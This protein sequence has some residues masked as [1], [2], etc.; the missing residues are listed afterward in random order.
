MKRTLSILFTLC[1]ISLACAEG[2]P[3]KSCKALEINKLTQKLEVRHSQI[4]YRS[5][6]LFYTFKE[7]KT[8]LKIEIDNQDKKF[9]ITATVYI[10]EER[11]TE[12]GLKKWLNNQHSDGLFPEVPR[13]ITTCNIPPKICKVTSHK[14][15]GHS[16]ERFGE[17]DNYK[18]TFEVKDYTDKINIKLKGF[19]GE[20]KVHIKTK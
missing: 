7:Q 20:S 6:L 4:D 17:Y 11:V 2:S 15:T 5:T 1:F 12:D 18:V 8:V 19:T 10:F 9:P 3:D 13:P 16:K 14:M